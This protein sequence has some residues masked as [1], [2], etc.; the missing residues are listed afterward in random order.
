MRELYGIIGNKMV[1]RWLTTRQPLDFRYQTIH[2]T[3]NIIGIYTPWKKC[4]K[5]MTNPGKTIA[6]SKA[7]NCPDKNIQSKWYLVPSAIDPAHFFVLPMRT[8]A[9]E[10]LAIGTLRSSLAELLQWSQLSHIHPQQVVPRFLC[11]KLQLWG[12]PPQVF[13]CQTSSDITFWSSCP[14]S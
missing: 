4:H 3:W 11:L 1:H 6:M 5:L 14:Y 9:S 2:F 7:L 10:P 13:K 12:L 8:A